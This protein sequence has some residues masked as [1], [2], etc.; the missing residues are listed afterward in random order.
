MPGRSRTERG[1]RPQRAA[2]GRGRRPAVAGRSTG[3]RLKQATG[4]CRPQAAAGRGLQQAA[5]GRG[6]QH[7]AAG[8]GRPQQAAADLGRPRRLQSRTPKKVAEVRRPEGQSTGCGQ[9]SRPSYS[10]RPTTPILRRPLGAGVRG[11][12]G[13]GA[14]EPPQ[15]K[16]AKG[17]EVLGKETQAQRTAG[18][19]GWYNEGN[20]RCPWMV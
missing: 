20:G 9:P 2:A 4:R 8:R 16:A 6:P 3:R 13:Q 12:A 17:A 1:R 10:Q 5:A 18:T 15:A 11:T 14:V 19:H 7:A